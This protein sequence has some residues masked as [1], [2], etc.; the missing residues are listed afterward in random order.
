MPVAKRKVQNSDHDAALIETAQARF[1]FAE[2]LLDWSSNTELSKGERTRFKLLSAL[3]RALSDKPFS[4]IRAAEICKLAGV[5]Y[6]LFYHY[7]ENREEMVIDLMKMFMDAFYKRYTEIHVTE[8]VYRNIYWPIYFYIEAYD[9][10]RGLMRVMMENLDD[11]PELKEE[12]VAFLNRWHKRITKSIANEFGSLSLR[13]PGKAVVAH[14]LGGML[15]SL[16]H[17]IFIIENENLVAYQK[18]K[19]RLTELC[20]MTWYRAVFAENPDAEAVKHARK[21]LDRINKSV[22]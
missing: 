4:Q 19:S 6:G 16:M 2:V 22:A 9:A 13:E 20:A 14:L 7:F 3:C 21:T 12:T 11:F 17:Q 10:N 1:N 18:R 15:D 5:S 8:D